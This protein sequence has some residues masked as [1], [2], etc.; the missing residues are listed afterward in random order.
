M[1]QAISYFGHSDFIALNY[2]HIK[3]IKGTVIFN[4]YSL[5]SPVEVSVRLFGMPDGYH[6]MHVHEKKITPSILKSTKC[7]SLLG[8]HFN[9][10]KPIWSPDNPNGTKHGDHVGDLNFNVY[11][12]NGEVIEEFEDY[13]ISLYKSSKNN[14]I[15]RS[16]I[17]HADKDD[18]GLG[19]NVESLITGNAGKR[20]ACSNIVNN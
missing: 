17:I 18:K 11:S 20:I 15:G 12:K 1:K 3:S 7:C 16:L 14:I 8:G 9:G 2:I 19:N 5:D 6:G 13:N 10:G 4:Q